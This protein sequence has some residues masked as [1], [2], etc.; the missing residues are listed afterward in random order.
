MTT[1]SSNRLRNLTR[2]RLSSSQT[3]TAPLLAL[4]VSVARR[5]CSSQVSLAKKASAVLDTSFLNKM[6][7]DVDSR[8]N[9]YTSV[10]SSGGTAMFQRTSERMTKEPT[11]LAP[12]T[13]NF[14][15]VAPTRGSSWCGVSVFRIGPRGA[16]YD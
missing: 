14:Q 3:L 8:K 9:L 2:R 10:V 12:P 5:C 4:N 6:K 15:V 16:V 1:R 7:C 13:M 11:A